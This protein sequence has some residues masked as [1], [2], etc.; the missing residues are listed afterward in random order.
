[1]RADSGA[2]GTTPLINAASAEGNGAAVTTL[3]EAG[4]LL[5]LQEDK[6]GM[7]ALIMASNNNSTSIV[8]YLVG[9]GA[10]PAIKSRFGMTALDYATEKGHAEVVAILKNPE[11]VRAGSSPLLLQTDHADLIT[12]IESQTEDGDG[13][14]GTAK[15]VGADAGN[16]VVESASNQ[17][18][19]VF[20]TTAAVTAA[21]A[22]MEARFEARL[23][24]YESQIS[25][26]Q[27]EVRE[28][29]KLGSK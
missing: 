2:Q 15:K 26:L 28:L 10:D 20:A 3:V 17:S 22:S 8:K 27:Q 12:A 11:K 13:G 21:L 29:K 9:M 5:D 1:M 25:A 19:G 6:Y 18:D 16:A 4:A 14:G 23:N 7:T 24:A